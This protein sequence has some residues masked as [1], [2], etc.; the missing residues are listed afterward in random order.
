MDPKAVKSRRHLADFLDARLS[1]ELSRQSSLEYL[2][3]RDLHCRTQAELAHVQREAQLVER[4][5][6]GR[7]QEMRTL[8]EQ[9]FKLQKQCADDQKAFT[10][11]KERLKRLA[12]NC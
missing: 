7:E 12:V 5:G 1:E 8:R 10:N 4:A 9:A 2:H 11:E 6:R 3:R